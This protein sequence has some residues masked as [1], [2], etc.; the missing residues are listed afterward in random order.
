MTGRRLRGSRLVGLLVAIAAVTFAIIVFIPF[1]LPWNQRLDLQLQAGAYGEL[2][3]GAW[4]ELSGARVG[5]GGGGEYKGGYSLIRVSID[6]RYAPQLHADTTAA[7][8]PPGLL[9]PKYVYPHGGP[10]R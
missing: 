4:V 3:P 1:S 7:I 5:A 6:A 2:N 9:G 10:A 8:R